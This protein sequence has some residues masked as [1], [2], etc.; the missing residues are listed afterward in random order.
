MSQQKPVIRTEKA[1]QLREM[2][3]RLEWTQQQMAEALGLD[4]SYLS[5]LETGLRVAGAKLAR[6]AAKF[7][8]LSPTALPLPEPLDVKPAQPVN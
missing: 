8:K 1:K 4:S 2:R 6:R 5:Q 3:R 7:Y